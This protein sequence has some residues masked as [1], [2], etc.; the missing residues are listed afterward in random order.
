MPLST[1]GRPARSAS[2]A[3]LHAAFDAGVRLVDTADAYCL[4]AA[5]TGHNELLV[6]EAIAAW[7]GPRRDIVV[8]TKGGHVRD[9]RGRWHTDGRPE[10]LLSAAAASRDRLGVEAIPLYYFHRPDPSVPFARSIEALTVLLDMGVVCS[11]GVSNVDVEQLEVAIGIVPVAA[12]QNSFSPYDGSSREVLA[13]C[14]AHAMPFIAWAPLGGAGRAARLGA[15]RQTRLHGELARARGVSVAQVVLAWI[16]ARSSVVSVI[17]GAR[18]A[19]SI[20]DGVAAESIVLED[21]EIGQ[22]DAQFDKWSLP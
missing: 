7:R 5:D 16:L 3:T 20:I 4:T 14:D 13:W 6:A 15:D 17:P 22:L 2:I 19:A 10:H 18:R 8:A 9:A 21:D 12:V 11:V 1:S